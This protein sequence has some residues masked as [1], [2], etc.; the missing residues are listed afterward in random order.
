MRGAVVA[1]MVSK[2]VRKIRANMLKKLQV[3]K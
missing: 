3:W 2:G 1:A